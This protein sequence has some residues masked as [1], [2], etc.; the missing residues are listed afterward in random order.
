MVGSDVC[1]GHRHAARAPG[2]LRFTL[3]AAVRA[4]FGCRTLAEIAIPP[5]MEHQPQGL[6][7]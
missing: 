4:A 3:A 2:R 7:F 6:Y 1:N 5:I